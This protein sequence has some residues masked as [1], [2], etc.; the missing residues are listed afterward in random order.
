MAM[1]VAMAV[2][3][4][5]DAP[6]VLNANE[7]VNVREAILHNLAT[8]APHFFFKHG[9]APLPAKIAGV[10]DNLLRFLL[11]TRFFSDHRR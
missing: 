8:L 2:V 3:I 11:G 9:A 5:K 1:V 6:V 10:V 7:R 4:S